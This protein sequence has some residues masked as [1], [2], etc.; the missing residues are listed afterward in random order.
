MLCKFSPPQEFYFTFNNFR[1]FL[2]RCIYIW[3]CLVTCP[4]PFSPAGKQAL[5]GLGHLCLVQLGSQCL[6]CTGRPHRRGFN[7]CLSSCHPSLRGMT[8]PLLEQLKLNCASGHW[9]Q[10]DKFPV[11]VVSC[12][13]TNTALCN[14]HNRII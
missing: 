7:L 1:F 11:C 10:G 8:Q 3:V 6:T 2:I 5:E 4:M 12:P 13:A 14:V 9:Y